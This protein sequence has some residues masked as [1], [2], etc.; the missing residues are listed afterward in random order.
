MTKIV[1]GS[2]TIALGANDDSVKI[3][4]VET[5]A[6][7]IANLEVG[8]DTL[9]IT[10]S[11]TGT[12]TANLGEGNDTVNITNINGGTVD[13]TLGA[14]ADSVKID[15]V[16]SDAKLNIKDV[17]TGDDITVTTIS[18]TGTFVASDSE[19]S[20]TAGV[21]SGGQAILK[22]DDKGT[23]TGGNGTELKKVSISKGSDT[24][25]VS[26]GDEVIKLAEASVDGAVS[27][28]GSTDN[29]TFDIKSGSGITLEG[30]SGNDTYTFGN[31]VGATITDFGFASDSQGNSEAKTG[32]GVDV[33]DIGS[34]DIKDVKLSTD[35]DRTVKIGDNITLKVTADGVTD[36]VYAKLIKSGNAD[37]EVYQITKE[38]AV[39]ASEVDPSPTLIKD[40][41]NLSGQTG[42]GQE[43][44]GDANYKT[45]KVKPLSE[46]EQK[47][48]TGGTAYVGVYKVDDKVYAFAST[49]TEANVQDSLIA[50][51]SGTISNGKIG[52]IKL[53][54]TSNSNDTKLGISGTTVTSVVGTNGNDEIY[55]V[56]GASNATLD[57][58]SGGTDTVKFVGE[59]TV[60]EIKGGS[61]SA[62]VSLQSGDSNA[63]NVTVTNTSGNVD[64]VGGDGVDSLTVTTVNGKLEA[65]LGGG[66]DSVTIENLAANAELNITD[67]DNDAIT[68]TNISGEATFI[69]SESATDNSITAKVDGAN[70]KV[71]LQ[72][73][74]KGT[75][76][77]GSGTDLKGVSIKRESD[78]LV[79]AASGDKA[80]TLKNAG[81][82]GKVS[83]V[84][85]SSSDTFEIGTG[86][87]TLKGNGGGD[88]YT[89]NQSVNTATIEDF[90]FATGFD[91][92][93]TNADTLYIGSELGNSV[94]S[95]V[96]K[97]EGQTLK[98]G[99]R[100]INVNAEG[101]SVYVKLASAQGEAQV[102]R[103]SG[104][105]AVN[106]TGAD[107]DSGS[108][109]QEPEKP[110][111]PA[112]SNLIKDWSTGLDTAKGAKLEDGTETVYKQFA[113]PTLKGKDKDVTSDIHIGVYQT[114]DG[115]YAFASSMKAVDNET[116]LIAKGTG[117]VSGEKISNITLNLQ[118]G[119]TTKLGIS[120]EDVVSVVGSNGA[121]EVY[122][123]G[124]AKKFD[125]S[126]GSETDTIKFVNAATVEEIKG[127][128]VSLQ[129]ANIENALK[130]SVTNT[131]GNIE[132]AG[133]KE[134]D[135]LHVGTVESGE[136]TANLGSG[137]D[138]VSITS[139]SN[140]TL[141]G[142]AGDD[143]YTLGEGVTAAT[144]T[145]FG[146]VNASSVE[147]VSGS[148]I[149]TIKV[150]GISDSK[151]IS[152][153]SGGVQIGSVLLSTAASDT[154]YA[155][156]DVN[157]EVKVYA[158]D[159]SGATALGGGS[160]GSGDSGSGD[161][162]S[163]DSGS[164]DSGSGDS[165]SDDSGSG[166]G[167]GSSTSDGGSSSGGSSS[168]GSSSGGSG[169]G[170]S[171]SG[172]SG[173]GGSGSG[174][175]S[176]GGSGSGGSSSG[177]SGSG[178]GT[179]TTSGGSGT[180]TT[181]G[182]GETITYETVSGASGTYDAS[183][184]S[185][186][187]YVDLTAQTGDVVIKGAQS[188]DGT[189]DSEATLINTSGSVDDMTQ[190]IENG[191]LVLTDASGKSVTI[192][193]VE[194]GSAIKVGSTDNP[195]VLVIGGTG[196]TAVSEGLAEADYYMGA[197]GENTAFDFSKTDK[198]VID[199][200]GASSLDGATYKYVKGVT[201]SA[202]GESLLISGADAVT[203]QA[204][205]NDDTLFGAG[206]GKD[207]LVSASGKSTNFMLQSGNGEDVVQGFTF[208][209]DATSDK[210]LVNTGI[211]YDETI[212]K[213]VN[214]QVV[215]GENGA[216]LILSASG[217]DTVAMSY[218][219]GG[220]NPGVVMIDVS[221]NGSEMAFNNNYNIIV[222]QGEK[223]TLVAASGD[224]VQALSD[225][226]PSGIGWNSVYLVSD[227][228]VV[229]ASASEMTAVNGAK[230]SSDLVKAATGSNLDLIWVCGGIG[231]NFS[232][233]GNDTLVASGQGHDEI[234]VGAKMGDDMVQNVASNDKIT[235]IDTKVSDFGGDINNILKVDSE[236]NTFT[237]TF[238]SGDTT[239]TIKGVTNQSVSSTANL[240]FHFD[241]VDYVWDG[242]KFNQVTN[243]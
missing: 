104:S 216:D 226:M 76:T 123:T 116:N 153:V 139:G 88:K 100:T 33:I 203:L 144:I 232:D 194:P 107:D 34:V 218:N 68:V 23:L 126:A 173:S 44:T 31:R 163:G 92:T 170:G 5:G 84:G 73:T 136:L 55:V 38:G 140:I 202:A 204:A 114:G 196:S 11:T 102:Y 6:K 134:A 46:K 3:G 64:F 234:F 217:Q 66:K 89:F 119:A 193:N 4:S 82:S 225:T 214:G 130:V 105:G 41:M 141:T 209:T 101:T 236:T 162:G 241:D 155:N 215:I 65:S 60:H 142:G 61:D 185:G 160:S 30:G 190:K 109:T 120:G 108:G 174:G 223:S 213:V 235:F 53:E 113:V 27:V 229:D 240:T 117:S 220:D 17:G 12:V 165:G 25:K 137:N 158:I 221:E 128:K 143:T 42:K 231:A 199:L 63:L 22:A 47:K 49:A 233:Q 159:S 148:G 78:T 52:N 132:F 243:S 146:F 98:I 35:E 125:F 24:L 222:G 208:G 45:F 1:S 39:L 94:D 239:T 111:T 67:V 79:V 121:D 197:S 51:G 183:G 62:K 72:A 110:V 124:N 179:D 122:V 167:S 112:E 20:I 171:G 161:S 85:S 147:A 219:Y 80:I 71:K 103:I 172:G 200:S 86:D 168:G 16:A 129:S 70:G 192:E 152:L 115:V 164:D 175:S 230:N 191:N 180:D 166:S 87:V 97:L 83:V 210:I 74:D 184:A 207:T 145:D 26:A 95:S 93:D 106:K 7:V 149:D 205:G 201:G 156:I 169:S 54:L 77:G 56:N 18:G 157:G 135:S 59:S 48:V 224:T 81:V 13:V 238:A 187:A 2:V 177:G 14:G 133:G 50:K 8:N 57:F 181:S 227:V 151:N 75:L 138:S 58:S 28:K 91:D 96:I 182:G 43:L 176:S 242:N 186:A 131:S 212:I 150:A 19:G 32:L 211:T 10:N 189:N 154:V 15:S 127:G 69:A 195:E 9:E 21:G 118:S 40:W 29:D 188:Y 90:K 178:T 237:A 36:E 228:G 206:A 198:T 99:S 37:A